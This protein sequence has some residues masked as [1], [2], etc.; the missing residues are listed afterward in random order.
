MRLRVN[1]DVVALAFT[2]FGEVLLVLEFDFHE[3]AF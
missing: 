3:G 2:N 1:V